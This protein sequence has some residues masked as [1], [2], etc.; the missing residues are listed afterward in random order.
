[1]SKEQEIDY[2]NC[3]DCRLSEL[4]KGEAQFHEKAADHNVVPVYV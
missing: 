3:E 4:D 2:W 1:M